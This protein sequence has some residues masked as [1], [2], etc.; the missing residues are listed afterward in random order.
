MSA[1][2]LNAVCSVHRDE[3]NDPDGIVLNAGGLKLYI[4]MVDCNNGKHIAYEDS[5]K[6]VKPTLKQ[7]LLVLAYIDEVN[8][9]LSEIGGK[10]LDGSFF[11]SHENGE[12]VQVFGYQDNISYTYV[13]NKFSTA[14]PCNYK[15]RQ[16]KQ[17]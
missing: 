15:V 14:L 8:K 6:L 2:T 12:Y 4:D 16:I 11:T 10:P 7:A 5:K 9:K 1:L 13:V 17:L 3:L